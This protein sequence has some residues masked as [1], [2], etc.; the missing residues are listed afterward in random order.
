MGEAQR[1]AVRR[2]AVRVVSALKG[3][4]LV[5]VG[6]RDATVRPGAVRQCAVAAVVGA[7]VVPG[8]HDA[9]KSALAQPVVERLDFEG[10]EQTTR[11][12]LASTFGD[13]SENVSRFERASAAYPVQK[14]SSAR[15]RGISR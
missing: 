12:V 13:P 3:A 2:P 9:P 7:A 1:I 5:A 15:R 8:V 4:E 10:W 6:V 11:A 14:R